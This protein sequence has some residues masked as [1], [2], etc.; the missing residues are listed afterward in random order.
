MLLI[1]LI[2]QC[3]LKYYYCGAIIHNTYK[4][5][6]IILNL[7]AIIVII[8]TTFRTS[9]I[10]TPYKLRQNNY[11]ITNNNITFNTLINYT[12]YTLI[13]TSYY[14][15]KTQSEGNEAQHNKSEDKK[16]Q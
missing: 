16:K 15:I 12:K 1:S 13:F 7:L 3:S 4:L 5:C 11:N 10:T 6:H 14:V 2:H 8:N 9:A